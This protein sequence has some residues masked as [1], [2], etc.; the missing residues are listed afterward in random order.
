M[1]CGPHV[2]ENKRQWDAIRSAGQIIIASEPNAAR[3]TNIFESH[4]WFIH[5][6]YEN[7][8]IFYFCFQIWH[9]CEECN[10]YLP[11]EFSL[12]RH[13]Q[14]AHKELK[15]HPKIVC[16]FCPVSF[17]TAF[18]VTNFFF[19]LRVILEWRHTILDN[20]PL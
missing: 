8:K 14:L 6:H 13:Q 4:P 18:V 10:F 1:F 15:K 9:L 20:L 16:Q 7:M 2:E 5:R 17:T 12:T 3:E 11:S 19:F